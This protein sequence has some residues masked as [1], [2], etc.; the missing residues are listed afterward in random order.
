M[1]LIPI[2]IVFWSYLDRPCC[3][4]CRGHHVIK[5]GS[6]RHGD[7]NYKCRTCGRQFIENPTQNR[8]SSATISLV[9]KLLLE[10]I[11]LAGIIRISY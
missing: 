3:P 7:Q 6:T 5:N 9:D 2:L 1:D 11:S 4:D 10:R 8:I